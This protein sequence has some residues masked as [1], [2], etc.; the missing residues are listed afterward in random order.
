MECAGSAEVDRWA[1]VCWR[2]CGTDG[3]P[4]RRRDYRVFRVR[5]EP[6]RVAGVVHSYM[7]YL[8]RGAADRLGVTAICNDGVATMAARMVG[9]IENVKPAAVIVRA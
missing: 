3:G 6:A 8:K 4:R 5:L 7:A 2:E 1:Q 9:I